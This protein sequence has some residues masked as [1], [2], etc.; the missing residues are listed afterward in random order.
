MI[1]KQ[2]H[3]KLLWKITQQILSQAMKRDITEEEA[4]SLYSLLQCTLLSDID[5]FCIDWRTYLWNR[6]FIKEENEK[7]FMN[8]I[9]DNVVPELHVPQR[10]NHGRT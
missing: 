5:P 2:Q 9:R 1:T 8:K 4:V 7:A 10:R 3:K 6:G